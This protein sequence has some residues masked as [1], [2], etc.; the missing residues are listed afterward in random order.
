M[1][2]LARPVEL[3]AAGDD[4]RLPVAV[5]IAEPEAVPV[6]VFARP[7]LGLCPLLEL[8]FAE[9]QNG[10]PSLCVVWCG[11]GS[12]ERHHVGTGVAV[13]VADLDAP[14][15]RSSAVVPTCLGKRRPLVA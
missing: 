8:A 4:L 2:R 14:D 9:R 7:P 3:K 11:A 15:H 12:T 1:P 13:Q 5:E 10:E 6:R